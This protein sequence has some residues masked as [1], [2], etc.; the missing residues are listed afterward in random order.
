MNL[1]YYK[2]NHLGLG[3]FSIL[4][5]ELCGV[6]CTLPPE[7]EQLEEVATQF[8]SIFDVRNMLKDEI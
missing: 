2:I 3:L 5:I 6:S 4:G 8:L 7:S 1:F